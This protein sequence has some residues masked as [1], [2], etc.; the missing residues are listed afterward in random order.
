MQSKNGL[1]LIG[2]EFATKS[3]VLNSKIYDE[4][5]V[6]RG[7][8]QFRLW[9][10]EKSKLGAAFKK[11]LQND[12]FKKGTKVLYLG[13]ASGTTAS[14]ISDLIT[15]DGVIYGVEFA[16]RPLRDLIFNANQ[17]KNIIPILADA[18]ATEFFAQRIE[19][20]DIIFQDIAQK[21]QSEIF[22]ENIDC[23]LKE[24]GTAM[25]S[26]KSRSIDVSKKVRQVFREQ[27]EILSKKLNVIK[28][29]PLAP[30]EM[31]HILFVCKKK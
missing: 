5:V 19:K 2:S 16:Q 21:D 26:I 3:L 7:K 30:Y 1:Y 4:K 10:P 15:N 12:Y 14:H 22:M 20:V 8:D 28:E 17:R 23:F 29:I 6:T 18:R 11:G 31:D 9:D 13:I 25:I 24:N 27:K